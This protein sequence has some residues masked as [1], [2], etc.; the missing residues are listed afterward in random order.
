L[1]LLGLTKR[2]S[3]K[4]VLRENAASPPLFEGGPS[5][6]SLYGG[7]TLSLLPASKKN[8]VFWG[9]HPLAVRLA[10]GVAPEGTNPRERLPRPPTPVF[11][12]RRVFPPIRRKNRPYLARLRIGGGRTCTFRMMNGS[13]PPPAYCSNRT[14][15]RCQCKSFAAWDG[16]H[17]IG[18]GPLRKKIDRAEM[19]EVVFFFD[20]VAASSLG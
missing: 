7:E 17:M 2:Q 10:S 4:R 16:M 13:L 15:V 6:A 8:V 1:P 18:L 5:I 9:P 11:C 14:E 3:H 20:G 19:A 12:G